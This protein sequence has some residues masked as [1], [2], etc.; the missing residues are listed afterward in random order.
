MTA[1][2]APPSKAQQQQQRQEQH[3]HQLLRFST[4]LELTTT[5][6]PLA[7]PE[8]PQVSYEEEDEAVDPTKIGLLESG[9]LSP[10]TSKIVY[11]EDAVIDEPT[12]ANALILVSAAGQTD[13]GVRRRRNEDCVLVRERDG[14]FVVADGM[15]GYRGGELASNLAVKTIDEAFQTGHF[16]GHA[17]ESIPRRASELARAIQMANQAIL[18]RALQ[19]RRL[20]GMGTTISAAHFS[21][22]KQRLYIGHVGDSRI[23][24]VRDGHMRQMTADHTMKDLGIQG[25]G[26]SHLSRAVGVWPTVPVDI[27]LGKPQH[28]DLYMMCSDGLT[29]MVKDGEIEQILNEHPPPK[30]VER[31]I[32]AANERGGTDNIT[33]VVIRVVDPRASAPAPAMAN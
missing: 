25:E 1:P 15:G 17:H 5:S 22:N 29:K 32:D 33:V 19:D 13:K 9:W 18:R 28:G 21:S 24:C 23:Y 4:P 10:P 7:R 26:A 2:T 16:Q 30:A 11:D 31:L 27:I 14:L 6:L 3:Q 8:L 12:Q 20:E